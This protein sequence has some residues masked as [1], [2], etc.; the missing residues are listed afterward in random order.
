MPTVGL[1]LEGVYDAAVIPVLL[2]RCRPKVK[3]VVRV[4][5]GHV[6]KFAGIV[7][8]LSRTHR[9][10]ERVLVIADADGREPASVRQAFESR[11]VENYRFPVISV[12]AVQEMEAWLIA[13]PRALQSVLGVDKRFASP[14]RVRHPKA[15]LIRLF[16]RREA[17]TPQMAARIAEGAD[18]RVLERVCPS[19]ARFRAAALGH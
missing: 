6:G 17:Y 4:C 10:L 14:E 13:D 8:E 18:V 3:P 12:I 9:T 5:R 15:E 7:S 11:F 2:R 16:P 19:F 1:I